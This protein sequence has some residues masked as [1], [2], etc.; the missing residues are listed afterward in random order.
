[1]TSRD[2]SGRLESKECSLR[3]LE[4]VGEAGAGGGVGSDRLSLSA[5]SDGVGKWMNL[6]G[7]GLFEHS[8]ILRLMLYLK[9]AQEQ[10]TH[11]FAYLANTDPSSSRILAEMMIVLGTSLNLVRIA[12]PG[13]DPDQSSVLWFALRTF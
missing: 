4:I 12:C 3:P 8:V 13:T 2:S 5:T 11:Q 10:K 7:S 9:D 6:N 1:M